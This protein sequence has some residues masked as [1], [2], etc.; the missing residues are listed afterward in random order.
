MTIE[1]LTADLLGELAAVAAPSERAPNHEPPVAAPSLAS[2]IAQHCRATPEAVAVQT[3]DS[4]LTYGELG[5]S[6]CRLAA[7][8][9]R[10]GV[11]G[12]DRVVLLTTP[13]TDTVI[14]LLGI[15]HAGAAWVPL[16]AAHPVTRLGDQAARSGATAVVCDDSTAAV[17]RQLGPPVLDLATPDGGPID[18]LPE[19]SPAPDDI[20]YVIFTSGTT[21]RPK[22]VPITHAAVSTYLDWAVDTFGYDASDR[23]AATASICFDASVR[24]LLAP[25]LVG[26][27]VVAVPR[28]VVRDPQA[29][30]TMVERERVTVWSS[31]PTLWEHLLQ[32]AERRAKHSGVAPELTALRWVHVG[33]E[34]LSPASVRR[35]YDLLGPTQRIVN[36]YGPTEAT[37]NATF[38]IIESR[39]RD[40]E[41][42]LP[43]GRP[44]A[45]TVVDVVAPDGSSCP[46]GQPGE[47]FLAG[48]GLTP[49]YVDGDGGDAF[50]IRAGVPH[51]RTGDRVVQRPDGLLEF[52]GR[53]DRQVK[54]RGHR[55]EPGEVEAALA[56][57][58]A[59][60]RATVVA[61]CADDTHR[62]R[63]IAY[64]E[65]R[66]GLAAPEPDVLRAFAAERL[67]D[68]LVPS[69]VTVIAT[70]PVTVSGKV[71]LNALGCAAGRPPGRVADTRTER[72]LAQVWGEVLDVDPVCRDDDFFAL[73]GDSIA[74]LEVF[75]RLEPHVPTL[76]A[77][78][79]MYRART[80]AE[81]A[82]VI[83]AAAIQP[84]PAQPAGVQPADAAFDLTPAQRGF[85][86]AEALAP[87]ARSGWLGCV[88]LTGA[89]DVGV[90][91]H[92]VDQLVDRHLMLRVRID[93]GARPPVQREVASP[94]RVPVEMET[95]PPEALRQHLAIER[96][97]RFDPS[98]WPLVRLRL[99]RLGPD[100]HALV[101]HAH[102]LIG[103]GFSVTVLA[104]DLLALYD[105]LVTARPAAL[106][107]LR[108]TFGDYARLLLADRAPLHATVGD[109]R[110]AASSVIGPVGRDAATGGLRA[111]RS[112]DRR[113]APAG[114]QTGRDPVRAAAR[115][116]LPFAGSADGARR[117]TAGRRGHRPGACTA[118]HH[119]SGGAVRHCA[120]G[121]PASHWT[122]GASP[123][124]CG[125]H[126]GRHG[127]GRRR[128]HA[129]ARRQ[130]T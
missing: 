66:A 112:G 113:P 119:A 81:L 65:P 68:Y 43:I 97:H 130:F 21:G 76:P 45:R 120:P 116:V 84:A 44:V 40:D 109:V 24:Q 86:L 77:P 8:L 100:E 26:A 96:E 118:R 124:A 114:V 41:T 95:I 93:A 110:P 56:G 73:G 88:R 53:I 39:P 69:Q 17:A 30:L 72:L 60:A 33:G 55:V 89:L 99:L 58:P 2:R 91:Q 127:Q 83:D 11:R 82:R 61:T 37:I 121:P 38:H 48:P 10:A 5:S 80:L 79:A 46:P 6:A 57:H 18:G 117:P 35:W 23:L 9:R 15:L 78:T 74:V 50:V 49:G 1:R 123:G 36:L 87:G 75:A 92:A 98:A 31:V 54:I 27:T 104:R 125:R 103:D 94:A 16:D 107:P 28:D 70:T 62:A 85:L 25:L 32:A 19:A 101:V 128:R 111:R 64:V 34:A 7:R 115:R 3:V 108:S 122:I 42:V 59:V 126:G 12:G 13:A 51:Y 52:R 22:G 4:P 67:P 14:G 105:G 71:H 47:L 63:L 106:P 90:F 129:P 102:H 20:A 29:L